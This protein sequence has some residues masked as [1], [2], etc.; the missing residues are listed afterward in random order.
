MAAVRYSKD[1]SSLADF[2]EGRTLDEAVKCPAARLA[3]DVADE[4]D[5]VGKQLL[6]AIEE[7]DVPMTQ[8]H[9]ALRKAGYAISRS[10]IAD[11]RKRLCVCKEG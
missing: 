5:E 2:L 4:N 10:S 8:I 3:H 7:Y 1:M 6:A 9:K 11:H